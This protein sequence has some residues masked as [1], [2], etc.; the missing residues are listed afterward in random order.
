MADNGLRRVVVTGLGIVSS[1]GN[2]R[3]EVLAALRTGR[4]GIE[5]VPEMQ[6][7]GFRCQVAGRVKGL[8]PEAKVG[9]RPLS[10]AS[11]VVRYVF[12]AAL[13]ALED[14]GLPREALGD[15][16]TAVVVGGSFPGIGE[17]ARAERMLLQSVSPSRLGATGAVKAMH[18][19]CSGN[20][21]ALLGVT[22]RAY[23]ICSSSASGADNI[24]H[25]YELVAHGAAD[26]CIA[27]ASED[28]G[29]RH[30]GIFVDNWWGMPRAWNDDPARAC[31]PYDRDR[32]GTV[33][34]EG[35]G[36]LVLED[37]ARAARR[38]AVPY[39]EV[40][41]YAA[42]NDG[43]H[44]FDPS[45]DGLALALGG[46]MAMARE[47]GAAGVD[48]VNA[49]G[50]GTKHDALEVRVLAEALGTRLPLVSSTKGQTG[51]AMGAAGAHEAIYTL[52]MLRHGFVAATANLDH[53]APD[54]QGVPHV[55]SLVETALEAAATFNAG[56]GGSNA[57]LV[58]RQP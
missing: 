16:R 57:C 39:A 26:V 3:H 6:E 49:H 4:S 34:S 44:M 20:L 38:G 43:H 18:S 46:A 14:A 37:R 29:W 8:R 25:G 11:D 47:H 42:A 19:T 17:A 36:I 40:V 28:G 56:L 13:E 9:R 45:R 5:F 1:I 50:T 51:H 24:G 15:G 30:A 48:Y 41:G 22:G 54:C 31:R 55:R 21:A 23:S 27:G 33:F 2:D 52:L 32:Q 12:V 10:T 58:F 7:A 53:V 35:A